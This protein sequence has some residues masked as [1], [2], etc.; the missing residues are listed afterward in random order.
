VT[1]SVNG[2]DKATPLCLLLL[3][4]VL[5][6]LPFASRAHD[7]LRAPAVVAVEPSRLG[8]RRLGETLATLQARR[9]AKQLPGTPRVVAL[10]DPGQY[11]LARAI[12]TRHAQSELWYAAA[13]PATEDDPRL[14][15]LHRLA[16]DRAALRFDPSPP[17]PG[18]APHQPNDPLWSR[19]EELGVARR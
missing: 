1:D 17:A 11:L 12:L 8:N 2:V 14:R 5:E 18:Q 10:L 4:G 19:L 3:P 16:L 13:E 9:L 15:D 6:E 7:L